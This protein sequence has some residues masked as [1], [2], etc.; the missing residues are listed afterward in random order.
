MRE[1][2]PTLFPFVVFTFG[3]VVESI[4]EL[5]N[6]SGFTRRLINFIFEYNQTHQSPC[7]KVLIRRAQLNW[8]HLT[9][10]DH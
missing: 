5:E 4:K 9:K 3:L 10:I 6:V 1:F 8:S 2:A 7:A